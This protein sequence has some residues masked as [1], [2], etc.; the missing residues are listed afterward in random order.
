M[1]FFRSFTKS[2]FSL[3]LTSG[4]ALSLL[5]SDLLF[6]DHPSGAQNRV[7]PEQTLVCKVT[8]VTVTTP[9]TPIASEAFQMCE[10][11][12]IEPLRPSFGA[13]RFEYS[14][15]GIVN[16]SRRNLRDRNNFVP[17]RSLRARNATQELVAIPRDGQPSPEIAASV[18]I[19]CAEG[20]RSSCRAPASGYYKH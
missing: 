20:Q 5:G 12:V 10:G 14:A 4:V 15:D 3:L 19:S 16:I 11:Q 6:A 17:V 7:P 9:N 2:A 18:M 1:K 8:P 13:A